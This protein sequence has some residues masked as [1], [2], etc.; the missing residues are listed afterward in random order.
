MLDVTAYNTI[1]FDCDG[2][3]LDSNKV[4]TEAFYKAALEYGEPAA[5]SLVDHHVRN[6][7]ISR[8]KKFEFF[9][10]DIVKKETFEEF[11]LKLLLDKYS[12]FV[13][14]GLLNCEIAG[15]LERLRENTSEA[16]WLVASGGDQDELRRLFKERGIIDYF[17][18]GIYGSPCTK[19][20]ILQSAL[21]KGVISGS[22]LFVGDS[23]YDYTVAD[24]M[25][26]DFVFLTE[27]SEFEDWKD[28][29]KSPGNIPVS[30][31]KNIMELSS[32]Y[33]K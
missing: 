25:R 4:K 20:S 10:T 21:D 32:S 31:M 28:F 14:E 27:W 33:A 6:G 19:E 5:L 1:V 7:G 8:Y 29:F 2:V 18:G 16:R 9:L 11:E 15:G 26:F 12:N 17:D 13:W 23:R 24:H 30:I 3:L 22:V